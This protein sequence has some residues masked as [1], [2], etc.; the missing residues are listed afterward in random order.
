MEASEVIDRIKRLVISIAISAAVYVAVLIKAPEKHGI[1]PE[2][3]TQINQLQREYFLA[4]N[5][6]IEDMSLRIKKFFPE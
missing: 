3:R 4:S 6:L 2:Q 1:T 5:Q